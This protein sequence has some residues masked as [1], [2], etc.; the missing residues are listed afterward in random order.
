MAPNADGA[1]VLPNALGAPNAAGAP[2]ALAGVG[3]VAV[4]G[5]PNAAVA[6]LLPNAP[7]GVAF[8]PD[9]NGDGFAAAPKALP[10]AV[11]G[12]PFFDWLRA[13]VTAWSRF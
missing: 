11:A 8:A 12:A 3:V 1:L 5:W 7:T 2:N 13:N 9:P 4:P 6:G 10:G